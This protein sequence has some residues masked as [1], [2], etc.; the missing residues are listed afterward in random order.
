MYI[1]SAVWFLRIFI[2]FLCSL[3]KSNLKYSFVIFVKMLFFYEF[4]FIT[5]YIFSLW[6]INFKFLIKSFK[7]MRLI[8]NVFYRK[9]VR[10][11]LCSKFF[12]SC[13]VQND[14]FNVY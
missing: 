3:S 2:L 12:F 4:I 6:R 5:S 8:K 13:D 1:Y 11:N 10:K 14:V 9:K 7:I